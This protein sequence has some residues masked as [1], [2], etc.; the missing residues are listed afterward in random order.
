MANEEFK[1][2]DEVEDDDKKPTGRPEDE[3]EVEIVDDTP[4]AD[5]GRKPLEGEV[6]EPT[7]EEVSQYSAKVQDRIKN[8][9]HARHDE[10]RKREALEREHAEMDKL[11]RA[12]RA[13]RDQLQQRFGEGV[14]VIATQAKTM[15]DADVAAAKAKLKAAMEAFDTDATVEAQGELYEAQVRKQKAED[16]R[17]EPTQNEKTVVQSPPSAPNPAPTLDEKTSRWMS[18]NKWFGE[19]G[20]KAMTGYALGLHQDL[21]EKH[22][23]DYTRTD[24]YFSQIDKAVRR[25]FPDRFQGGPKKPTSIVAPAGRVAAGP[26]KIQLTST[27]VALAK[28]FGM[29]PQQYAMEVAKL[30]NADGN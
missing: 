27:Q 14:E 6:D 12:T 30:E 17:F 5:R 11:L 24:E 8:L 3:I 19:G 9:T 22:G 1:F 2:P 18:S 21:V 16:F 26:R 10:R 4:P 23:L 25:T 20:D 13:E 15:A 29:T 7:D 28:K